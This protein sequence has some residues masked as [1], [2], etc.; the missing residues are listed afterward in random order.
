MDGA[1]EGL[2]LTEEDELWR[3]DGDGRAT[4][5]DGREAEDGEAFKREGVRE[6][7]GLEA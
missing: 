3:E 4:D 6:T 7:D 1:R 2:V 5:A